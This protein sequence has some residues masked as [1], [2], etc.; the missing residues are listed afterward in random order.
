MPGSTVSHASWDESETMNSA[1][2]T[3]PAPARY[4]TVS[5]GL[6]ALLVTSSAGM[7]AGN[8]EAGR[9]VFATH[10]AICHATEA[11]QN[12]IGPSLDGIVGSKS[13]TVAGFDF[14]TAMKNADITWDEA[15]LDKYLA[16]PTGVVHGTKMFVNLPSESDRQNVI[17]YLETLKK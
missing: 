9:S 6:F 14:S 3:R 10:C 7:A 4:A 5:I 1:F 12:K 2:S 16:N 15:N 8:P 13:G 17:A 11:G